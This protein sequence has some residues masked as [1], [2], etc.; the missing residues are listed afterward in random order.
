MPG[1]LVSLVSTL[2]ALA[3]LREDWERSS[4]LFAAA[5]T[6]FDQGIVRSP[7]DVAVYLHYVAQVRQA[8]DEDTAR[9]CRSRG[10]TMPLEDAAA[11][12]LE[13]SAPA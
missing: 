11:Y 6:T 12:G 4:V 5:R 2:G 8:L 10:A 13:G 1:V 9:R 7:S 3:A